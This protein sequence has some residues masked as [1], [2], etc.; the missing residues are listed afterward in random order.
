MSRFVTRTL[1]NLRAQSTRRDRR[2][3]HRVHGT[4][5]TPRLEGMEART[6]LSAYTVTEIDDADTP[7]TLRYGL[8]HTTANTINFGPS[9]YAQ[10]IQLVGELPITRDIKILGPGADQLTLK[11]SSILVDQV[12]RIFDIHSGLKVTISGLTLFD[13]IADSSA[14]HGAKGGAIYDAGGGALNLSNDVLAGNEALGFPASFVSGSGTQTDALG[15]AVYNAG[16]RLTVDSSTFVNNIAIG[17]V[18][19][20]GAGGAIYNAAAPDSKITNDTFVSNGAFGGPGS[21]A[22]S[23]SGTA[24]NGGDGW[25]GAFYNAAPHLTID[26]SGFFAN[27]ASGGRGGFSDSGTAGNGGDGWGGAF[28]NAVD[29]LTIHNS[30]FA[31]S[32]A[33]PFPDGNAAFGGVGG[34]SGNGTAGNGGVGAGGAIYNAAG[35][36]YFEADNSSFTNESAFGG[37]GGNTSS[38]TPGNGGDGRGGAVYDTGTHDTFDHG[39][40]SGDSAMGGEVSA[41]GNGGNGFGGGFYNAGTDNTI[42]HGIFTNDSAI[43]GPGTVNGIGDGGAIFIQAGSTLSTKHLTLAN[44]IPD[45]VS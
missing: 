38:G 35:A 18:S 2:R 31:K 27:V 14:P 21:D 33:F 28:Y 10:T 6:L 36:A 4:R 44:N 40:F 7:G 37:V 3:G 41:S 29:H 8:V 39:T 16:S 34:S 32:Q 5:F 23:S 22:S 43:G 17:G 1:M 25:G 24:G 26:S 19:S 20:K 15:G 42:D 30:T 13:G 9:T 11:G 12:N 45:D